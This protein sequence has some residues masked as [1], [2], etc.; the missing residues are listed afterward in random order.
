M[1]VELVLATGNRDKQKEMIALLRDVPI[2]IRTLDE[3]KH[4]PAIIEDG[5]TCEA[6]A[7]KKAK[8]IAKHTGRLALADDTGLKVDALGG[9]PGV[10][11]ARYAGEHATY[12]DNC[13]KLLKALQDVPG[14]DRGARF[15]T[16][17]AIGEPSGSVDVVEG[18]LEGKIAEFCSGKDGFGYDPVFIVPELGKTLAEMTLEEKNQISHRGR[19]LVKAKAVLQRNIQRTIESGRSAAR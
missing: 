8:V 13:Q 3:F 14:N 17:V 16:V 5:E 18:V 1:R 12:D 6:N 15:L 7:T 11:A 2:T 10:Y 9:Q 19:A 4:V